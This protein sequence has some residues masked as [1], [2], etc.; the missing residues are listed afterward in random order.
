MWR[1]LLA[2]R[3]SQRQSVQ[4]NKPQLFSTFGS[5]LHNSDFTFKK[6]SF[7]TKTNLRFKR[8]QCLTPGVT[9]DLFPTSSRTWQTFVDLKE[10]VRSFTK[11]FTFPDF[12]GLSWKKNPQK[13]LF[14]KR[15]LH[16]LKLWY[17]NKFYVNNS[18]KLHCLTS[19][20]VSWKRAD[21]TKV[22]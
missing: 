4:L 6:A 20:C 22:C 2:L 13:D 1:W 19:L 18:F 3:R 5:V 11:T 14:Y 9:R 17:Y 12:E 15:C 10:R 8:P 7:S 21:K 16:Y